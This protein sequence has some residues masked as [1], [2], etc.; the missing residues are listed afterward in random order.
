MCWVLGSAGLR[1]IALFFPRLARVFVGSSRVC[2]PR[3]QG[4]IAAVPG[5]G[6]CNGSLLTGRTRKNTVCPTEYSSTPNSTTHVRMH[7][8]M[9]TC[10]HTRMHTHIPTRAHTQAP[11][12]ATSRIR[13]LISGNRTGQRAP[14][15]S[16][17][18][19]QPS[20]PPVVEFQ[21]VLVGSDD[22][23]YVVRRKGVLEKAATTVSGNRRILR[24]G[25][26]LWFHPLS[27]PL[28]IYS[29]G[30]PSSPTPG[31]KATSGHHWEFQVPTVVC[32]PHS[33][34]PLVSLMHGHTRIKHIVLCLK[35][36]GPFCSFLS[37][38]HETIS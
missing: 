18:Q 27:L 29:R 25:G 17:S 14:W 37:R 7:T 6:L 28:V 5:G 13:C 22:F 33:L 10:M 8:R 20:P 31:L 16:L 32:H 38:I 9:H 12:S 35:R 3:I 2:K 21:L 15:A 34:S 19:G 36:P 30:K 26:A 4:G 11:P 1:D 23:C 24:S